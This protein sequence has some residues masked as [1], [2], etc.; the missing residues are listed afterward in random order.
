MIE[1]EHIGVT[2]DRGG[3]LE[4]HALN[5]VS[6]RIDEGEFVTVIGSNGAGKSTLLGVLAGDVT[7]E[8]GTV[9]IDGSAVTRRSTADRAGLVARVFQDPRAGSCDHLSVAEN[10]AVA[11]RRGGRRGF[12]LAAGRGDRNQ[13]TALLDDLGV[14]LARRLDQP[15][16]GL[17]GGQRQALALVMA[18]LSPSRILLLDEHTAAL[19]PVMAANVLALTE[20]VVRERRLTALMVTHSMRQAID[21]GDR[22]LMLHG[23][24]IIHDLPRAK[25]PDLTVE[26][27]LELFERRGGG[28]AVTDAMALG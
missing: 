3:P 24:R 14:D 9:R 19:D 4:K 8:C 2:F 17:S 21:T 6:L 28:A 5:D 15:A 12:S 22:V 10:L 20:R 7:P 18:T 27:L 16:A 1:I 25:H 23:G 11:Q 26:H 13:Y